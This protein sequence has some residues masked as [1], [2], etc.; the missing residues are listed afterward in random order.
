M[1]YVENEIRFLSNDDVTYYVTDDDILVLHSRW[2]LR[3]R[4]S[5]QPLDVVIFWDIAP[6][7]PFVNRRFG[8]TY[9]LHA[10]VRR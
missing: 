10:Q 1:K 9:H 7:S 8:G 4:H 3:H 2:C 5:L 6:C